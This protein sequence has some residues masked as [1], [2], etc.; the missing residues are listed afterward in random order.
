MQFMG[1]DDVACVVLRIQKNFYTDGGGMFSV[2]V[3]QNGASE[4]RSNFD[5]FDLFL[6][7]LRERIPSI[8]ERFPIDY[9]EYG[10]STISPHEMMH[11]TEDIV[12]ARPPGHPQTIYRWKERTLDT[13]EVMET[14]AEHVEMLMTESTR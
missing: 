1:Y 2:C 9:A 3:E 6:G 4:E 14:I 7:Y 10:M 5:D 13:N 8:L 12:M 11:E